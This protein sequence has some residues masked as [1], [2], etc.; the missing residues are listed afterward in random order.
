MNIYTFAIYRPFVL[1]EA[2]KASL[3][4]DDQETL[5]LKVDTKVLI[6]NGLIVSSPNL[7]GEEGGDDE[8]I[9]YQTGENI[10]VQVSD[11]ASATLTSVVL[12]LTYSL[13][14]LI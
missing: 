2:Q 3:D 9:F 12:L 4:L 11:A 6:Y 7:A 5:D 1:S 10:E 14:S 8:S 13:V